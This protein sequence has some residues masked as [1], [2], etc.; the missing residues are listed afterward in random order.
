MNMLCIFTLFMN[1]TVTLLSC[2]I[3]PTEN[4]G[5]DGWVITVYVLWHIKH[6]FLIVKITFWKLFFQWDLF[7]HNARNIIL[8][9]PGDFLF[10]IQ[11][12]F[13]H[14]AIRQL[15]SKHS[16]YNKI[17][18]HTSITLDLTGKNLLWFRLRAFLLQKHWPMPTQLT[19]SHNKEHKF[20]QHR[21]HDNN[22][23]C[24]LWSFLHII[25]HGTWLYNPENSS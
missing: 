6:H 21:N 3:I 13:M 5:C 20:E 11:P 19:F 1:A 4:K 15:H 16:S 10:K 2:E 18:I 7:H 12:P 17:N 24:K 9:T 14:T 25:I 8:T 22:F 23:V